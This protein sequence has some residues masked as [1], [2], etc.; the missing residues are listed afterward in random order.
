MILAKG[1]CETRM[2]FL[3][4]ILYTVYIYIN[5]KNCSLSARAQ[6]SNW[7]RAEVFS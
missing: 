1:G 3:S 4:S 2:G 7:V 5:V 6:H